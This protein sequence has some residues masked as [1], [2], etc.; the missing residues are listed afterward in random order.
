L[1]KE[2]AYRMED[3]LTMEI[4]SGE[5]NPEVAVLRISGYLDF[6]GIAMLSGFF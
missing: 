3:N 1:G 4:S 6:S 5:S 2:Q